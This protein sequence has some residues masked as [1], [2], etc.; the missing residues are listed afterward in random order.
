MTFDDFRISAR[1]LLK[2]KFFSG[3]AIVGLSVGFT[4][5]LLLAALVHHSFGYDSFVPAPNETFYLKTKRNFLPAAPWS[6]YAPLRFKEAAAQS[7]SGIDLV[8]VTEL[9]S[10]IKY[11][12]HMTSAALLAT[13]AQF[14]SLFGLKVLEGDI[15]TALTAPDALAI[16]DKLAGALFGRASALGRNVLITGKSLRI[17]AVIA[18][19]PSNSTVSYDGL[20]GT[21]TVIWEAAERQQY[22]SNW[23]RLGGRL[24]FKAR[25]IGD[26]NA[27][28]SLLQQEVER[29]PLKAGLSPQAIATLGDKAVIDIRANSLSAAF[30]DEDLAADANGGRHGNRKTIV[31]LGLIGVAILF[32]AVSNYVNLTTVRTLQ[33][34]REIGIRK[35]IGASAWDL[36][37]LFV[38]ESALVATVATIFGILLAAALAGPFESMLNRS[39]DGVI[40]IG[41]VCVALLFGAMVGAVAGLYPAWIALR[42]RPARVLAGRRAR[43]TGGALWSRRILTVVQFSTAIGLGAVSV[44]IA[45]QAKYAMSANPGFDANGLLVL[46]LPVSAGAPPGQLF[47]D[48]L[49]QTPGILGVTASSHAIGRDFA[50]FVTDANRPGGSP[51]ALDIIGVNMNFFDVHAVKPEF[52][53]MF[54]PLVDGQESK[55]VA[56]LNKAAAIGLGYVNPEEAVGQVIQVFGVSRRIVGIAPDIRY[57]TNR[58]HIS[59]TVFLNFLTRKVVTIRY[60]G[61][62]QQ[63]ASALEQVFRRNFPDQLMNLNS[64]RDFFVA[65]YDE[66]IRLSKLIA[67]AAVVAMSLGMSGLYVLSAFN[68]RR[69]GMQIVIRKLYGA[70]NL[71]I[72]RLVSAE[73]LAMLAVS[74]CIALPFAYLILDSHQSEFIEKAPLGFGLYVGV[75]IAAFLMAIL[76]ALR[77]C[78]SAVRL[79]PLLVL[80]NGL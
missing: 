73:L 3:I 12:G 21:A 22:M 14:S 28:A 72:A 62:K 54:D 70:G 60:S 5:F 65:T 63:I 8:S 15:Q 59:P 34:Q 61:E 45:V 19:P 41:F 44:G 27:L 50:H 7:K 71:A 9:P 68:V 46:D 33:R 23:G 58:E 57:Q 52:G 67:A 35:A 49:A 51:A 78:W 37:G 26:A 16:T 74:G 55:E 25:S 53:R 43:E 38:L 39:L 10:T 79:P 40:T 64:A 77:H 36:V 76:S 75:I 11:D 47:I 66:D 48:A 4:A 80:R 17:A 29:S 2:E 13:D 31:A 20:V 56:V 6:E 24:Y 69:L 1:A 30:L 42:V 32:L 18:H